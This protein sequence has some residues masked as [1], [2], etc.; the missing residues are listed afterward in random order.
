[1]ES[2]QETKPLNID[3]SFKKNNID[4]L[5]FNLSENPDGFKNKDFRYT[6]SLIYQIIEDEFED[7]FRSPNSPVRNTDFYL[8]NN[9]NQLSFFITPTNNFQFYLKSKGSLFRYTSQVL[10]NQ[11]G[12][13]MPLDLVLDYFGGFGDIIDFESLSHTFIYLNKL[14]QFVM[15]LIEKLYFIPTVKLRDSPNS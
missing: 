10:N 15:K 4:E 11:P 5:F 14:T 12:Y 3:L 7:V 13:V 1:M 6:L 8:I 9:N 2:K